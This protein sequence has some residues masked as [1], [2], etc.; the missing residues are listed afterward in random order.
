MKMGFDMAPCLSEE[1]KEDLVVVLEHYLGD[2]DVHDMDPTDGGTAEEIASEVEY[3]YRLGKLYYA[4]TGHDFICGHG[5]ISN[6]EGR[7]L[8]TTT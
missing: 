7:E 3:Y 5:A 4:F 8:T 1:E 6:Y 2:Y